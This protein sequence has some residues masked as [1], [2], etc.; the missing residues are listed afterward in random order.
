MAL[1]LRQKSQ[2]HHLT[3][4]GWTPADGWRLRVGSSELGEVGRTAHVG[5]GG[6]PGGTSH[7]EGRLLRGLR[8]LVTTTRLLVLLEQDA[9]VDVLQ[10]EQ[11]KTISKVAHSQ[12]STLSLASKSSVYQLQNYI[13]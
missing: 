2:V 1:D 4:D 11:N 12:A 10:L 13:D 5:S 7:D 8:V 6:V 9:V 3:L